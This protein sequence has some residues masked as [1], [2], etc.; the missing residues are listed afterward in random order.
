MLQTYQ[1]AC[2]LLRASVTDPT[3][4]CMTFDEWSAALGAP[5]LG[6]TSNYVDKDWS[7][8][9]IPI[10]SLNIG[11]ASKSSIQLRALLDEIVRENEIIG[12]DNIRIHKVTTDNEPAGALAVDLFTNFVGAVRCVVHTLTLSV[13]DVFVIGTPWKK[14]LE[15]V[16]RVTLYFNFHPKAS[17]LL[18]KKQKEQGATQ[19]RI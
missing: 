13:N 10:A 14:H 18:Q 7:L 4:R 5:I 19:D 2:C 8:K 17:M 12:S 3:T 6:V 9:C 11:D 1:A 15:I 16:N